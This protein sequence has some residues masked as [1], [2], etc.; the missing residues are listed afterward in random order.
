MSAKKEQENLEKL[1]VKTNEKDILAKIDQGQN[2]KFYL[3]NLLGD[4]VF[5]KNGIL[6]TLPLCVKYNKIYVFNEIWKRISRLNS[7]DYQL[8]IYRSILKKVIAECDKDSDFLKIVSNKIPFSLKELKMDVLI[9]ALKTD[10][11]DNLIF[12][13]EKRRLKKHIDLIESKK[14]LLYSAYYYNNFE[15]L[16]YFKKRGVEIMGEDFEYLKKAAVAGSINILNYLYSVNSLSF[17]SVINWEDEQQRP[18]EQSEKWL[19]SIIM[20]NKL[21]GKLKEKKEKSILNKI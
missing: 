17:N 13:F 21:S 14:D 9:D 20:K 16:N 2:M 12:F 1:F 7:K 6:E 5:L 4:E 19:N 15:L 18:D 8:E 3:S 10:K 11:T